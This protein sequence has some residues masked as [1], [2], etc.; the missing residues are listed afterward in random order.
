GVTGTARAALSK[1][2]ALRLSG[3]GL[4]GARDLELPARKSI[5]EGRRAAT[6]SARLQYRNGDR[7]I[8]ADGFLDDRSY[9]APPSDTMRGSILLI[10]RETSARASVAADA[11][12]GPL[13]FQGQYWGH[14]LHRVTRTFADPAME[15]LAAIEDLSALRS[16]ARALVTKAFKK[17]FRWIFSTNVGHEKAVVSNLRG[18]YVQGDATLIE[19]A[20]GGQYERKKLRLDAAVGLAMPFGINA[21]PWPEAKASA[22]YRV[23]QYVE[24][25]ATS[26]YKGRVPSLRE[27]FD[28]LN[29]NPTLD[30]EKAFHGELRAI[31]DN[32]RVRLEAAPFYRRATGIVR[33][34]PIEQDMGRL[35]NLG[36]LNIYGADLQGRVHVHPMVELGGSYNYIRAR[37]EW[38]DDDPLDRLPHNRFDAWTRL[39]PHARLSA[40]VRVKYFGRSIDKGM[41][42]SGYATMDGNLTAQLGH[43]YLAV[44]RIDDALD[45]Q[46][47]TRAGFHGP[48]RVYSFVLQGTWQ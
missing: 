18:Q 17:D 19:L 28:S 26:G 10:D 45:E 47:E 30:P 15:N 9:L 14:Y 35:I 33:A 7:I 4:M 39:I 1:R 24:L 25:V 8:V 23:Q 44:L 13:Q 40:L 12:V 36:T 34:S 48:G 21:D 5:V 46:P 2:W 31:A 16:G 41:S 37:T 38:A 3:S 11:K 6:G 43:D 27:R 42:V 22:R 20:A 32:K 29:G